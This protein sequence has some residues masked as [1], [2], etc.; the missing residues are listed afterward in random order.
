MKLKNSQLATNCDVYKFFW[1][2][3][4]LRMLH[5]L[6]YPLEMGIL[7]QIVEFLKLWITHMSLT[8]QF[9]IRYLAKMSL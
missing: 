3:M 9:V 4:A 2:Y 1:P 6:L 7:A 5:F 8:V